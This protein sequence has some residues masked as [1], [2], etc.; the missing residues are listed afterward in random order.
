MFLT[1][2]YN[3]IYVLTFVT[4]LFKTMKTKQIIA[5][6]ENKPFPNNWFV[7]CKQVAKNE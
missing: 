7:G 2:R 1:L 4:K 5:T 3:D 6:S